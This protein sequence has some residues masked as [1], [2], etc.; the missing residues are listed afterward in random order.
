MWI[1]DLYE[2]ANDPDD[3]YDLAVGMVDRT[4][5]PDLIVLDNHLGRQTGDAPAVT[6]L[7]KVTGQR[8]PRAVLD[9]DLQAQAEML[10]RAPTRSVTVV[11]LGALSAL[12]DLLDAHGGLVH[13]KVRRV[14]VFAGDA[15]AGAAVEY[16]VHQ[17]SAAYLRVMTSGLP[18]RWVPC[19]D[20]GTWQAGNSSYTVTS[21]AALLEGVRPDVRD[22]FEDRFGERFGVRNLWATGVL[23]EQPRG[24]VW[25]QRTVRLNNAGTVDEAGAHTAVVDQ[26][27]VQD[28]AAF[29]AWMVEATNRALRAL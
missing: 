17:D 23:H 5:R 22:W 15:A 6:S 28:R 24:A 18:I 11:S 8:A 29:S 14:L 2:P 19:F 10:R 26:L 1:S 20:G 9:S 4:L 16:N 3:H 21:D 7:A 13:K 12:A 27:V 25:Q